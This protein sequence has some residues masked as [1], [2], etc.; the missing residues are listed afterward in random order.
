MLGKN[1]ARPRKYSVETARESIMNAFWKNGFEATS[2]ADLIAATG[3]KKGSLYR[4]FG[5]KT[6]MFQLALAEYDRIAVIAT[7]A[8]LD[9]LSGKEALSAFLAAPAL[10]VEAEDRRGCMLCNSLSEYEKLGPDARALAEKGRLS[11]TAAIERALHEIDY[12]PASKAKALEI[13]AVYFGLRV[14]ARGGVQAEQ[15]QSVAENVINGL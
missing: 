1:M 14:L 4:A 10:S 8:K 13:L 9:S 6:A 3:M 7:I 11:L 5:D 12:G 2:L 15:I